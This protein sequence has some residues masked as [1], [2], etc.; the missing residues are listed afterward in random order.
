[1]DMLRE[2]I[3]RMFKITETYKMDEMSYENASSHLDAYVY[4]LLRI[5]DKK[6]EFD[7][8]IKEMI[9]MVNQA[10]HNLDKINSKAETKI[11]EM[12]VQMPLL[13]RKGL[14]EFK[15]EH[16]NPASKAAITIVDKFRFDKIST[17]DIFLIFETDRKSKVNFRINTEGIKQAT[18]AA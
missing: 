18:G 17:E 16:G 4:H 8:T 6:A 2:L 7:F 15:S 11:Q 12:A 9:N 14:K 10:N 13:F 5:L 3:D 1:M